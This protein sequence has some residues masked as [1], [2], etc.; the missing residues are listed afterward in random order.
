[1]LKRQLDIQVEQVGH[2]SVV[3]LAGAIDPSNVEDFKK[4]VLPLCEKDGNSVLLDCSD[5]SY[6]NSTSIGLFSNY[7]RICAT[8]NGELALCGVWDKIHNIL[9]L[10]GLD[11]VLNIYQARD[12]GLKKLGST[13]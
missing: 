4:T 8:N 6:V 9:R 10:L 11:C 2:V 3:A 12:D 13:G 5:L 1:M 7:H